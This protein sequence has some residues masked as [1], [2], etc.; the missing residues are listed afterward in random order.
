M[1]KINCVLLVEDDHVTNF[2]N[3]RI[4]RGMKITDTIKITNNGTDAINFI[5]DFA[6][7]NSKQCPEIILL[8]LNMP[9]TDG[10][11]FIK[12]FKKMRFDNEQRIRVIVLTTSIH[13][14]DIKQI[15]GDKNIGYI[16][17][18]LVEEKLLS[19]LWK[20]YSYEV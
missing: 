12:A 13:E 10:F 9:H 15:I 8:D 3:E 7:G 2:L 6:L 1:N 14:Y 4:I 17:K 5:H 16:N 20:N 18:P 19:E 11:E